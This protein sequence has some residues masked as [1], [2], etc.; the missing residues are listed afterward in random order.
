MFSYFTVSFVEKL[1]SQIIMFFVGTA[2]TLAI[3]L[4]VLFVMQIYKRRRQ[5]KKASSSVLAVETVEM[6]NQSPATRAELGQ[7]NQVYVYINI[8]LSVLNCSSQKSSE[9]HSY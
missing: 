1:S 9:D 4:F 7:D 5:A 3:V 6:Q 8:S 2:V